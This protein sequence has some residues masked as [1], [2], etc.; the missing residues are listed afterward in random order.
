MKTQSLTLAENQRFRTSPD[1]LCLS[2]NPLCFPPGQAVWLVGED[3]LGTPLISKGEI[4]RLP[5][6]V[7]GDPKAQRG[8]VPYSRSQ[9]VNSR[10]YARMRPLIPQASLRFS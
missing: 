4:N 2:L 10:A 8:F 5:H 1:W 9:Y 6:A 3:Q 7:Y